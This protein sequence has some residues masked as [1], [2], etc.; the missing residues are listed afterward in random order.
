MKK[1]IQVGVI[2]L[3]L[4]VVVIPAY[5]GD[6]IIGCPLGVEKGKVWLFSRTFYMRATKAFWNEFPTDNP[7]MVNMPDGWHAKILK[8]SYRTEF[9]ITDRLSLGMLLTYWNKDIYKEVWKKKPDGTWM[10]K[11]VSYYAYGFGDI[12][13]V[14]LFKLVKNHPTFESIAIGLG[15]KFDAADNTL[16][17]HSIGT[18]TKDARFAFL[19]HDNISGR[20]HLCTSLW[21]EHRGKIRNIEVKND[22][23]QMVEWEKSGRDIGDAL[24]YNINTEIL[25]DKNGHYRIVPVLAGWKKLADKDKNG[26][27]V[28]NSNFYEY[29]AGLMF[30]YLPF[31][32]KCDHCKFMIG[33]KTPVKSVNSFNALISFRIGAMWTF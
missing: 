11:P 32:E 25:L 3:L 19:T 12:W 7:I 26:N 9:G 5:A 28:K 8:S 21:Y 27:E 16:V 6:P 22:Q 10:K 15:Y 29:S 13:T 2:G 31:G 24:G 20:I 17:V 14:G 23:G 1:L 30:I 18:G 4:F 33:E